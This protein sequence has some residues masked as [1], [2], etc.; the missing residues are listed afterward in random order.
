LGQI[1]LHLIGQIQSVGYRVQNPDLERVVI[2][3]ILK[4]ICNLIKYVTKKKKHIV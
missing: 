4:F 3:W 2:P 1:I